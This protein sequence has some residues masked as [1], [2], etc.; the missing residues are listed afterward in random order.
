MDGSAPVSF[1]VREGS[2]IR[3][4][5]HTFGELLPHTFEFQPK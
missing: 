4:V 3:Q 5:V 2:K 1:P